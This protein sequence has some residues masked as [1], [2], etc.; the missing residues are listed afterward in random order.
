MWPWTSAGRRLEVKAQST[1]NQQEV[2]SVSGEPT[3]VA[4]RGKRH[5]QKL[6]PHPYCSKYDRCC[7]LT[8]KTFPR[9]THPLSYLF[10]NQAASLAVGSAPSYGTRSQSTGSG[11]HPPRLS[12]KGHAFPLFPSPAVG[13]LPPSPL[14]LP[15][16][17]LLSSLLL[18]L[19]QIYPLYGLPPDSSSGFE[20]SVAEKG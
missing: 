20:R 7:H 12:I 1:A 6:C 18:L 9:S 8:P 16:T 14:S 10:F 15:T 11:P 4:N 3:K 19:L 17:P 13:R 5:R 2:R